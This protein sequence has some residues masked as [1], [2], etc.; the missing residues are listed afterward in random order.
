[1]G[2][3]KSKAAKDAVKQAVTKEPAP[4][5]PDREFIQGKS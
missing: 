4:D 2:S 5:V 3:A 1:M